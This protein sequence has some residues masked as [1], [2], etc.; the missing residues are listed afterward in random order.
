METVRPLPDAA[1]VH[2]ARRGPPQRIDDPRVRVHVEDGRNLLVL[3][4]QTYD[5]ITVE[6]T[7]IW[8][9][10]TANLYNRES[11]AI[12]SRRLSGG[13]VLSQWVQLHHT[14]LRQLANQMATARS[15]F[16]HAAFFV[17]SQ[18]MLEVSQTP[19]VAHPRSPEGLDDLMLADDTL[20][21][22][23]GDVCA[24]YGVTRA[25]LVLTDDNLLL[26]HATPRLN[27]WSTPGVELLPWRRPDV[28]T[29]V[30]GP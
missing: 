17:R 11:Y 28:T 22:F 5:L 14:S 23:I 8:L 10:G 30:L 27:A 13:G 26:E 24:L 9:A 20:D 21:A 7:S 16:A 1:W 12:A 3:Q 15:V 6:L 4:E 2:F 19:L 29:R 18:G 25:A